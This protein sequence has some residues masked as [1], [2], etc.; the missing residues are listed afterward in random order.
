M[1][2]WAISGPQIVEMLE[3]VED[4]TVNESNNTSH[5]EDTDICEERFRR[6]HQDIK[7]I[8]TIFEREMGL[9]KIA[10]RCIF[11]DEAAT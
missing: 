11:E 8:K 5:H 4:R 6:D 10:T 3:I 1:Q 7:T 2:E 9:L